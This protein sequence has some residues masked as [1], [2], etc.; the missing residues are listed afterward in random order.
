[1]AIVIESITRK[2]EAAPDGSILFQMKRKE[3]LKQ[4]KI[5]VDNL[6]KYYQHKAYEQAMRDFDSR[7]AHGLSMV[8]R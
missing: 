1:M 7:R 2:C 4:E 6:S 5:E 3:S 8:H